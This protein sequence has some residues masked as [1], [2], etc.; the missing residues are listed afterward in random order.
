MEMR[1]RGVWRSLEKSGKV[2]KSQDNFK[3]VAFLTSQDFSRLLKTSQDSSKGRQFSFD[4]VPGRGFV[5]VEHDIGEI[6]AISAEKTFQYLS[7]FPPV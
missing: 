6:D 5:Q 2:S 4:V 1:A 7:P 3:S